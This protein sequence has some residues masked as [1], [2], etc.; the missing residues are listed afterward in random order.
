[1][2][3][4]FG[5]FLELARIQSEVNKL[6]D[7][8]L[9][10]RGAEGDGAQRWLPNVDIC[11]T[12]DRLVVKC[13]VPGVCLDNL[14]LVAQGDALVISGDKAPTRPEARAKFHCMERAY[15]A[16]RRVVH[17]PQQV[18]TRGAE[19][20]LNHGVLVVLFP[21]VSNRR[22]EEVVIKIQEETAG[23]A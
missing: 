11:E 21:K 23:A 1:M 14:R 3:G 17:L 16:F 15:G 7:V 22:G 8:L 13:E 10:T 2:D 9:E 5:H 18:N 12:E 19:A 6:F 20:S 4:N